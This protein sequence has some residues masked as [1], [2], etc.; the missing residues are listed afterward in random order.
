MKT[1]A[2]NAF[3]YL[4]SDAEVHEFL[5]EAMQDDDPSVFI[6]ALGQLVKK[7]GLAQV[8]QA[9]GLGRESLYKTFSGKVQPRWNT[10]HKLLK[11]LDIDLMSEPA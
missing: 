8:A 1:K 7:R 3:D 5:H 10:V 6:V 11:T 2:F 9:A 4:E